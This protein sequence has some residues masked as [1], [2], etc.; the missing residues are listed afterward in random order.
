MSRNFRR[1][2]L[3]RAHP[4]SGPHF[5][6]DRLTAS[7]NHMQISTISISTRAE[8]ETP[9]TSY[10]APKFDNLAEPR[11]RHTG[12]SRSEPTVA[13]T[14]LMPGAGLLLALLLSLGLWAAIWQA[15]SSL[16]ATWL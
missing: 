14:T 13:A 10:T 15:V 9:V 16:A 6:D 4:H 11:S 2:V 12:Q 5:W 1:S 7:V 8:R 3:V